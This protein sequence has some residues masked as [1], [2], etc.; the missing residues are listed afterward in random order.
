MM[1]LAYR[2]TRDHKACHKAYCRQALPEGSAPSLRVIREQAASGIGIR[3]LLFRSGRKANG[4][5]IVTRHAGRSWARAP[6]GRG[7]GR[8]LGTLLEWRAFS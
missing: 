6:W 5:R 1:R 7:I 8:A 2:Y 4:A 3:A